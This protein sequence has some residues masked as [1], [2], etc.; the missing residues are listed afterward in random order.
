LPA[1]AVRSFQIVA[2]GGHDED[3]L[4]APMPLE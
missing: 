1:V 2:R 4:A 3:A